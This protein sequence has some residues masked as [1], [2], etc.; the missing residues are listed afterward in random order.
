MKPLNKDK[1]MRAALWGS[2]PYNL[3]AAIV[4][5]FPASALAQL[6]GFPVPGHPIYGVLLAVFALLFG[7]AYAWLAMQP[8]IAR[9]LVF[10]AAVGKLS[11]FLVVVVFWLSG[12]VSWSLVLAS[13]GDFLFGVTFCWWLIGAREVVPAAGTLS[14]QAAE[15][16]I[17]NST[18][19][20]L[21]GNSRSPSSVL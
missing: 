12:A 21:N 2:V 13:S 17:S 3:G 11:V 16:T 1:V 9:P 15:A 4:S 10:L 20:P 19:T 6:E 18:C 8:V 14:D 7:A 5:A